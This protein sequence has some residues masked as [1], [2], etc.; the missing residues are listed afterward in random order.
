MSK[1]I[2]L[3]K[4]TEKYPRVQRLCNFD[5]GMALIAGGTVS[6]TDGNAQMLIGLANVRYGY[7]AEQAAT[8]A[9]EP[10]DIPVCMEAT[11]E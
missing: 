7:A 1:S 9:D 11:N 4:W 6:E 5:S 8:D 3:P 10:D 2:W